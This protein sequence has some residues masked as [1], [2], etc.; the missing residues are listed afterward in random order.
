MKKWIFAS[1]LA[2]LNCYADVTV[3]NLAVAQRPGTKLVDIT[4]DVFSATTNLVTIGLAVSNGTTTIAA[5]NWSGDVGSGVETGA[6]KHIVWN[7]GTDWKT[8]AATLSFSVWAHDGVYPAAVPKTA[9]PKTGQTVSYRTGDDGDLETGLAWPNPR[10]TDLGSGTI[11]DNLTGLEWV[12]AP[13]SLSGN[14]GATTWNGAIDRCN[15]LVYAGH[16]DW[17]LPSIKELESLVNCGTY[18]PV[19]SAGHPFAG[20]RY[21]YYWS[22]TSHANFT[23]GAWVVS[24]GDGYVYNSSKANGYNDVWPV[25]GGQ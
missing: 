17:R 4:Y 18:Y 24:M 9:V 21:Y 25:R 1:I 7:M 15:N 22:G 13:H 16:S 8:N 10:F 19:L 3:T 11:Q 5:T 23:D 12:K 2:A 6:N 20:V 14:S